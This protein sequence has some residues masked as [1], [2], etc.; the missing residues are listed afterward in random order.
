MFGY[1]ERFAD[2]AVEGDSDTDFICFTDDRTLTSQ[3]WRFRYVDPE[4]FGPVRTAKMVKQLAHRF[5]GEYAE[6]LYLDNTIILKTPV[7]RIFARLDT[8]TAPMVCFKHPERDCIYEEA[9][10]VMGLGYDDPAIIEK[11]MM[12]YRL[13]GYPAHAGLWALGF[14]LRRHNDLSLIAVMESWFAEVARFSYRDQ[15]SFSFVARQAGFVPALFDGRLTDNTMME[16]LQIQGPRI[17]RGFRD[18]DYLRL[19]E[20]VRRSG[21]NAREH[22]LKYGAMEGRRWR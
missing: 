20:D 16:W 9:E 15:L 6:S 12:T 8:T 11:Q 1:S 21:M 19:N 5:V 22:Y 4:Q 18:E 13:A 10:I 14:Q 17:P 2:Q 7:D 3:Q